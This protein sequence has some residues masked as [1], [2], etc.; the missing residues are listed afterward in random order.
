M[1]VS[2]LEICAEAEASVSEKPV[3]DTRMEK[4]KRLLWYTIIQQQ[5]VTL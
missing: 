5:Q 2:D 3:E 4:R 1:F